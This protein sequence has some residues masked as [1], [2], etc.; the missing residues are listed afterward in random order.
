MSD[1]DP[2]DLDAQ[3]EQADLRRATGAAHSEVE[4]RDFRWLMSGAKG[5]RIV[6]RVLKQCGAFQT[7]FS[8]NAM[9]MARVE[10]GKQI[11]YWLMHEIDRLC[12]E[13]YPTMLEE[14]RNDRPDVA[15]SH[16][17]ESNI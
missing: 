6:Y 1:Y 5:R 2:T 14:K 17:S 4:A 15:S 8:P 11:A 7:S 10:G 16:R 12:P 9:E 3:H 13:H